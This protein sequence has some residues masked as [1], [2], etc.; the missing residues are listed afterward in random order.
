MDAGLRVVVPWHALPLLVWPV[1]RL[2]KARPARLLLPLCQA[3]EAHEHGG[4]VVHRHRKM[5]TPSAI[6]VHLTRT[7][8]PGGKLAD[9]GGNVLVDAHPDVLITRRVA[10]QIIPDGLSTQSSTE[11][12]RSS[13]GKWLPVIVWRNSRWAG[14]M[15]FS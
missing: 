6:H 13:S 14:S 12:I 3:H 4:G 9:I 7:G 15:T 11:C 10:M 1:C 8:T 2:A 5:R